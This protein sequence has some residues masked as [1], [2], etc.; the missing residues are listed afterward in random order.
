MR[1]AIDGGDPVRRTLLPYGHQNI[2][3]QDIASVTQTLRSDWLTTGPK[4]AEFEQ[5]VA[6][7]IGVKY[8]IA[9]SSGTAALH[10]AAFAAGLKSGDEAITTPLTFAATANAV[11]YQAANPIFSDVEACTLNIDP[12]KIEEKITLSTKVLLP[13]DYSG[14]PADMEQINDIAK[15]RNLSV[16]EDS[17]HSLGALYKGKRIG[18]LATM[19][20]FSM[21]PVKLITTAEGGLVTTDDEEV[22]RKIRIFRN[23]GITREIRG[24]DEWFY[25]MVTLGYNYRLSD[26]QCALGLSQIK[27]LD[28]FLERRKEIAALYSD[29]FKTLD[30][31]HIPVIRSDRESAWHLYVIQLEL[32]KLRVD[33]DQVFRALRA[34]NIGVNVHYIP[35]YLHPH[36]RLLGYEANSCPVA[37]RAYKRIITLPLFPS[38]TEE[39]ANNVIEAVHKVISAYRK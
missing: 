8:A 11:L 3:E 39:D 27:K 32:E 22:A 19:T 30:E 13:V 34:E 10:A 36:Y 18:T 26:L 9:L 5:T 12:S 15:R 2:D 4:V 24:R 37:E 31:V 7:Y 1:L 25:E 29:A 23:H 17:S 14:Q 28:H 20:V 16:I 21:H 35:V 38:M 6:N 33:R